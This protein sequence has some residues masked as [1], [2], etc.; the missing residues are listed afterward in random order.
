MKIDKTVNPLLNLL[1]LK[2]IKGKRLA[3][4]RAIAQG[5]LNFLA[6]YAAF[7]Q[8]FSAADDLIIYEGLSRGVRLLR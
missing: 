5:N 3:K 7:L 2:A 1:Q 8:H 6:Q 4:K